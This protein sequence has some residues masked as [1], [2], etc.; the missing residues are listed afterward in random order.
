MAHSE[1]KILHVL[2]LGLS[3]VDYVCVPHEKCSQYSEFSVHTMTDLV[4]M[5]DLHG[6]KVSD[7][8]VISWTK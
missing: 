5:F 2:K 4:N 8:S 3:V 1:F 7:H 6:Q